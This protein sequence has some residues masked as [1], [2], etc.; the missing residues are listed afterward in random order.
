MRR[1]RQHSPRWFRVA[2]VCLLALLLLAVFLP[3]ID[4]SSQPFIKD[5]KTDSPSSVETENKAVIAKGDSDITYEV[6]L[7][8]Q[9][10]AHK[11]SSN[12]TFPKSGM[13]L[14]IDDV[15]YD[16]KALKRLLDLPFDIAI[17][18]LPGAPKAR[19]AAELAH[20]DG[21]V[22]ML[23]LP[24][25]PNNPK[26]QAKMTATFLRADMGERKIRSKIDEAL[27][28]VPHV[29]GVNN[30]MGSLLTTMS[31][32]MRWVIDETKS[33]GLFFIDSKTTPN[34]VASEIASE[35]GVEWAERHIFLDHSVEPDALALAWRKALRCVKKHGGCIVIGHPHAETLAFLEQHISKSDM[36]HIRPVTE[37]LH[38][39]TSP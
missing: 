39:Q 13:A 14:I 28:R 35:M 8:D 20:A 36:Q 18:V 24:M 17:S 37:L 19:R 10:K 9:R 4:D 32:P 30:H 12:V 21:Q 38:S 22:V 16:L 31:D 33:R 1:R 7:P 2:L 23:H 11:P 25:E 27:R 29:E 5:Y 15:G 34:S 26:Y 6:F 3:V